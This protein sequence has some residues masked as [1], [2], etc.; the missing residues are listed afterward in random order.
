MTT[1]Y[2]IPGR[3][4]LWRPRP[5]IHLLEELGR[6]RPFSTGRVQRRPGTRTCGVSSAQRPPKLPQ[7]GYCFGGAHLP[8]GRRAA[9]KCC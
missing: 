9:G 6:A 4:G 1:R 8:P 3:P 7:S 5:R 2:F